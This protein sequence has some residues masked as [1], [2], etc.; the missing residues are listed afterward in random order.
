MA[1]IGLEIHLQLLTR[2]KLFCNCPADYQV[3]P[4]TNICEICTSQPGSKPMSPNKRALEQLLKVALALN[5]E[6]ITE[7]DIDI[8]RKHYFYPDLPSNYQRTSKP[9]ALN[10]K[11]GKVRIRELHIEEDPGRYDIRTGNVEYNRCGVP[12]VEVVTEPDIKSPEEARM[13]LEEF[14]NL[15]DYLEV[16]KR[17]EGSMRIDANVSLEGGNRVEIKNI[18]SFKGVY[19]ALQYEITRQKL[20]NEKGLQVA[21][22]TRHFDEAQGITIG[23]R[24]KESVDDYRYIPDPDLMPIVIRKK[25]VEAIMSSLPE[26]P[27]TKKERFVKQYCLEEKEAFVLC[28]DKAIAEAYEKLVAYGID[29]KL[30]ARWLNRDLRKQLNYRSITFQASGITV[31]QLGELLKKLQ[32]N[33]IHEGIAEE[34]LINLLDRGSFDEKKKVSDEETILEIVEGVLKENSKAVDD[35][36]AGNPKAFNFLFGSVMKKT[37][38]LA[39]PDIVKRI[40]LKKIQE[41]A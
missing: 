24:K 4:N 27:S 23:S 41:M 5:A 3:E 34:M 35:Y 2:S 25:D 31:E 32:R 40:L 21:Q 22:E 19:T 9:I 29:S 33:E 26:L 1:V 14:A 12:L 11:L 8:L 39:D 13:F 10:G 18:N 36:L 6:V 37:Q 17:E 20:L 28:Q 38:K 16:T 15:L 7:K 30:C